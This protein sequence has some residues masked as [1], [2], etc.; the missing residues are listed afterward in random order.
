MTLLIVK[1]FESGKCRCL[2]GFTGNKCEDTC[3]IG[4]YGRSCARKCKCAEGV[5]CHPRSG[6]CVRK[7][8]PGRQGLKCQKTCSDGYFGQNCQQKCS[9]SKKNASGCNARSG[10]CLCKAGF[11]GS[12]CSIPCAA[13]FFGMGCKSKCK[14]LNGTCNGEDGSCICSAGFTGPNCGQVIRLYS[15]FIGPVNSRTVL[16]SPALAIGGESVAWRCVSVAMGSVI[17]LTGRAPVL[18]ASVAGTASDHVIWA[19]MDKGV[20]R[21]AIAKAPRHVIRSRALVYAPPVRQEQ[22]VNAT[23]RKVPSESAVPKPAPVRTMRN[24]IRSPAH[25]AALPAT[26]ESFASGPVLMAS[27]ECLARITV[28]AAMVVATVIT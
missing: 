11:Q 2:S 9:C 15:L 5:P 19:L 14:C 24:A 3:A 7:C 28:T 10:K 26:T 22:T 12:D 20:P 4:T 16:F 23:A 18:L 21:S 13:G 25:V 8:P 17:R 6:R 27:G 1:A